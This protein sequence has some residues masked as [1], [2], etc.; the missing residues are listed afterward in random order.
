M[1]PSDII[2]VKDGL[3]VRALHNMFCVE[4]V[5]AVAF[6]IRCEHCKVKKNATIGIII[7]L[8]IKS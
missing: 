3:I 7:Q 1:L 2:D 8:A 4:S 5:V 6:V